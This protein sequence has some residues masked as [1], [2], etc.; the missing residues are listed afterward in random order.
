MP[1]LD[2]LESR[3]LLDHAKNLEANLLWLMLCSPH[4]GLCWIILNSLEIRHFVD[5]AKQSTS[6]PLLDCA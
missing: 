4:T 5:Y 6:S 3:P 1:V 2:S